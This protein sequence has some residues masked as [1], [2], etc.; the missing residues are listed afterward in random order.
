M[1][2]KI[3]FITASLSVILACHQPL[4]TEK[5]KAAILEIHKSQQSAHLNKDVELLLKYN[6]TSYTEI[7]KGF[8]RRPAYNENMLRFQSYFDAV[9]FIKW[10]DVTAPVINISDDGSMATTIVE[11]IVI[12]K[13]KNDSQGID[14]T[15]YAWLSVYIKRNGNWKLQQMCS[16]QKL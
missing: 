11:K 3:L 9:D 12:T 15:N 16:T 5:E 14:T 2:F 6:D 8:I 13:E 10:E 4:N 1:D 7:N